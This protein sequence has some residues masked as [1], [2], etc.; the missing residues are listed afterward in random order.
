MECVNCHAEISPDVRFCSECGT[1]SQPRPKS[2]VANRPM[3]ETSGREDD[4]LETR[5]TNRISLLMALVAL[6][7]VLVCSGFGFVA[8]RSHEAQLAAAAKARELAVVQEVIRQNDKFSV[9]RVRELNFVRYP[10]G[11]SP[12]SPSCLN[13]AFPAEYAGVQLLSDADYLTG[14]IDT[15]LY[16]Q[17]VPFALNGKGRSAIGDAIQEKKVAGVFDGFDSYQWTLILG[18]RDFSGVDATAPLS[19]GEKVDF[20]WN[21][22]PTDLGRTAGLTGERRSGVAYLMRS[23]NSLAVDRI[24]FE[25]DSSE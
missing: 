17:G 22:K 21:W 5:P 24:Q 3:S 15:S 4:T 9:C 11:C 8:L 16:S 20:N 6:L 13:L 14:H 23:G 12:S 10:K 2:E 7:F 25:S 1:A 19:D 18:C